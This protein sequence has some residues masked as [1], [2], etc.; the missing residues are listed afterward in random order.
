[1]REYDIVPEFRYS[2]FLFLF[3]LVCQLIAIGSGILGYFVALAG[4]ILAAFYQ[5]GALY[6]VGLSLC[7]RYYRL[8]ISSDSITVWNMFNKPKDYPTNTL[9]WMIARIPWY[10]SYYILLYSSGRI[11]IAIVK[12]HWKNALEIVHFPHS[13]QLSS[14]ELDYLKFLKKMG[15]LIID[16]NRINQR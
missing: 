6:C 9:R 2:K 4:S 10:R 1:M 15:L 13:G 7:N 14:A 11:P 12:P 16:I 5:F 3:A 8:Y